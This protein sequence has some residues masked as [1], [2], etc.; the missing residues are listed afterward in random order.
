M[1]ITSDPNDTIDRQM[2]DDT[3]RYYYAVID[4]VRQNIAANPYCTDFETGSNPL[5]LSLN[6]YSYSPENSFVLGTPNKTNIAG[7]NSGT[8]AWVTYLDSTYE[9]FDSSSLYSPFLFLEKDSCY[10]FDFYHNFSFDDRFHD[11]GHVQ[12][13]SDA[14][15]SWR[16]VDNRGQAFIANWYNTPHVVAIPNNAQ[17]AGWT[18]ISNGYEN[19]KNSIG[20]FNEDVYGIL[21]WRFESD[22][23][24]NGEGWSIDDFCIRSTAVEN[25][26]VVGLDEQELSENK[27]YL[28]TKYSKSS[29]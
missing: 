14:G 3:L 1:A 23:S 18:G 17:N 28:G 21:R 27:L 12:F 29:L 13:S 25:C 26:V 10:T 15:D 19:A 11:G 24:I 8:N 9:Q 7:A 22:G 16:S 2:E 6:P 4:T 20:G 5:W